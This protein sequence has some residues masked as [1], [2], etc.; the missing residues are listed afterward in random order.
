MSNLAERQHP[1]NPSTATS[2]AR[3]AA[4]DAFSGLIV[5]LFRLN[6]LIAAEGETL[7][8][9]AGQTTARWQLLASVEEGPRT[10]A[11]IARNLGLARQS[12]Q[13]VA[14]ALEAAGLVH[15]EDNPRHRRAKLVALTDGGLAKLSAIQAA[16]R[17]W[18]DALGAAV[19]ERD[20]RRASEVLDRVLGVMMARHARPPDGPTGG[21]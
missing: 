20:L 21:R 3:T 5:R 6:G 13:R 16:Q 10:V 18:A 9:P 7:A 12:V 17:P 8:R 1:V 4:G 19:G 14:D 2:P 11:Q 15:Y